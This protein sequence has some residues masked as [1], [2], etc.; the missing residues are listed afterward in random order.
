[1]TNH[2][3]RIASTDDLQNGEMKLVRAGDH[4]VLLARVDD[5]YHALAPNCTHYGAPLAE[6]ALEGH[7]LICPWHHACFDV[8]TGHHLQA[9]GI[10]GLPSYSLQIEDDDIFVRLPEEKRDRVSNPMAEPNPHVERVFAI[11]GGGAAGAYAAEGMREAGYKGHI[12]LISAEDQVPYDRPNCSKEYLTG[13]APEKW[14]PLRDKSFYKK[15]GIELWLNSKVTRLD[16]KEKVIHFA[17]REPLKFDKVVIAT[18]ATPR[19]IETPGFLKEDIYTLRSLVDSRLIHEMAKQP[20]KSRVVI[21]GGSFIGLEAA[22][23]L[24]HLGLEVHVV[25]P[26]AVPLGRIFGDRIGK[27]VQGLHEANG[28]HFHLGR[29]VSEFDGDRRVR[30]V[31][32]DNGEVV[33]CDMVLLGVGVTPATDFVEGVQKM[34]DGGIKVDSYLRQGD[35]IFVAGDIA[36]VSGGDAPSRRIEHWQVACQQ[37]RIAGMNAAGAHKLFDSVPFFWTRQHGKSLAYL[38]HAPEYDRI[39]YHGKVE[40]GDFLAFYVRNDEVKAVAGMGRGTDLAA[41]HG[42]MASGAMP[43]PEELEAGKMDWTSR[44]RPGVHDRTA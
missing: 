41:I 34:P 12:I 13:E 11:V 1:M 36:S 32:L 20:E 35:D 43:Q 5:E 10:D 6:G 39:I 40:E 17:D 19:T 26:E 3:I 29:K 31:L 9:P 44:L 4:E 24:R 30:G 23:S 37:G 33:G 28:V 16:A 18:G 42:L 22:S 2:R 7:R 8:R 25:A 15:H 14:M 21:V 27:M 38:G